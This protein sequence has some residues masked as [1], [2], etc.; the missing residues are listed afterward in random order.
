M[1]Q[2]HFKPGYKGMIR[3]QLRNINR[4]VLGLKIILNALEHCC[5]TEYLHRNRIF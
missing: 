1:L 3:T 2:D 5:F 4:V